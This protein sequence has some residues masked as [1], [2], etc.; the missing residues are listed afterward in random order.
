MEQVDTFAIHN[1]GY[2]AV[3]FAVIDALTKKEL[4]HLSLLEVVYYLL[5]AVNYAIT[6]IVYLLQESYVYR[7]VSPMVVLNFL[8]QSSHLYCRHR[9]E[10]V[11]FNMK[12]N[13]GQQLALIILN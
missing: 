5:C 9:S 4:D 10:T 6:I 7:N 13:E 11:G 3:K 1:P 8:T 12:V 2:V